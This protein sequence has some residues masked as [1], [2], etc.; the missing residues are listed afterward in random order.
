MFL[1]FFGI[2]SAFNYRYKNTSAYFEVDFN[3]YII[4]FGSTVFSSVL[5]NINLGIYDE[6]SVII[7]HTHTDHIGSLGTF[8]SYMKYK[9]NKKI[10]LIYPNYKI[11]D[12]LKLMGI[13]QDAYNFYM[14]TPEKLREDLFIEPIPVDH[15]DKLESYAYLIKLN[16]GTFYYSGDSKNLPEFILELFNLNEIQVLYQDVTSRNLEN[17]NHMSLKKLAELIDVDKRFRVYC[18]HLDKNIKSEIRE[19]G[20]N[21]G[22]W[23]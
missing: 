21:L 19:L 18:M 12:L 15:S 1:K 22:D 8:I 20:F 16:I 5:E 7:T 2:G 23:Q 11:I 17:D 14:K 10:N 3:L 4:D 6:V 13:S 9:Y